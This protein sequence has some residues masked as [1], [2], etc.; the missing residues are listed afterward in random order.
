LQ[1]STPKRVIESP[2]KRYPT[3][4]TSTWRVSWRCFSLRPKNIIG[5]HP[6][7]SIRN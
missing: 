2:A 5:N 3:A 1:L 6:E 4:R 7:K